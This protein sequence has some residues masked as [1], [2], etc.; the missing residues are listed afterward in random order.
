MKLLG[1]EL[2]DNPYK[3]LSII[4]VDSDTS[5]QYQAVLLLDDLTPELLAERL[6]NL[7]ASIEHELK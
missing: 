1:A 5:E 2:I 6:K 3:A 7:A 4:F